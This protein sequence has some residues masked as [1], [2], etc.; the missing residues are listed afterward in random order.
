MHPITA[1]MLHIDCLTKNYG[2]AQFSSPLCATFSNG[3]FIDDSTDKILADISFSHFQNYLSLDP[4]RVIG[5]VPAFELAGPREK[6]FWDPDNTKV[7]IV[8]CGGLAPGLNNVVQN[9]VTFLYER[10]KV[11]SIYGVPFGYQG[12]THDAQTKHFH[13]G[14]RRLDSLSVQ[15]IDFEAGSVLGTGRG[16][17]NPSTIV[18]ALMLREINILFAIGGDGTLA[19][20]NS[21][22]KEVK[23]RNIPMSII[24]IPK[25]IDNDVLWVSKT[26]GFES[27]VGKAVEA[28]RCAQSE[29]RSAFNG[30]GL[31]KIMGRNS[32]ALTATAAVAMNDIDF[33]LIPEVSVV[34]EGK[35]G[36]LNAIIRKILDKGYITIAVAEGAG[37][38]LITTSEVEKDASGNLKLKDIGKFLQKSISDE[39]KKRNI[40]FTLKYID[41]SYILRAQTTTAD[42]SVFCA[43]LG[44]N[45][46]HAAMAGKTGC[47]I[48]Y[49]HER[50]THVPLGMVARG[51]KHLNVNDSL[52]LSV[53]A[54]TGQPSSWG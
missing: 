5:L 33:V 39:F 49:A 36:L 42:D 52:W 24:G 25:T 34:L 22:Y 38:N 13:F 51:Q 41:P 30:I 44:Q 19:G 8:T 3:N 28:L 10:Y 1:E 35:N 17:S 16:H 7:A 27:A 40:D 9:L 6:I 12:F 31:V 18:D 54:A 4:S 2:R 43:N 20:A 26:F 53:L 32:G 23:K 15:N 11:R 45:A 50:F 29:A 46:V 37:Q 14:W 21:I 47:M 48:G